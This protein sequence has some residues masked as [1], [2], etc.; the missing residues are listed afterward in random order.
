MNQQ[1]Q[2]LAQKAAELLPCPF[3]GINPE[4]EDLGKDGINVFC[5][6]D[7]CAAGNMFGVTPDKWNTR[8]IIARHFEGETVPLNSASRLVDLVR[9]QRAE[10]HRVDLITDDEYTECALCHGCQ[11]THYTKEYPDGGPCRPRH[12]SNCPSEHL[13]KVLTEAEAALSAAE[14][15]PSLEAEL[16]EALDALFNNADAPAFVM[17]KAQLVLAKYDAQKGPR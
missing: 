4:V 12:A 3:C 14:T 13:R 7:K 2:D 16:A 10:L 9:H 5:D 15:Q 1:I 11:D 8:A 17:K 6:N